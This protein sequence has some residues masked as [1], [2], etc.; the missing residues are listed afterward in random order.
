MLSPRTSTRFGIRT[1]LADAVGLSWA[2]GARAL[3]AVIGLRARRALCVA[4]LTAA[5]VALLMLRLPLCPFAIVTHHPCPGC[6]L[7]RAGLALLRGDVV[8]A[9]HFHPLS[10]LIVPVFGVAL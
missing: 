8:T 3:R 2:I 5:C 4:A 9:F 7:T 6:G 1:Q 10:P